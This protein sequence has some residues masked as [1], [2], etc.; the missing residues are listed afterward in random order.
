MFE[1]ILN[2]FSGMGYTGI[3]VL[4][5]IESSFIPLPSE[6]IIPPAGYLAN[7]GKMNFLLIILA[8]TFGSLLGALFNYYLAK[9]LGSPLIH[10]LARSSWA[11]FFFITPEKLA[12]SEQYFRDKGHISTFVGRLIPVIRHLISIPAGLSKMPIG[13]FI[14]YTVLG[15]SV[16]CTVLATLGWFFGAN[17]ELLKEHY[18]QISIAGGFILLI[19]IVYLI[20]KKYYAKKKNK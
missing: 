14:L 19:F 7:L 6:L 4:M 15:A 5:A 13:E 11:K 20:W 10:K 3:T 18:H 16:W 9:H 12:A 8:G 17:E 2:L 1:T